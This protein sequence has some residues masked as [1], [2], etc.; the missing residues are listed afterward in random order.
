MAA[1]PIRRAKARSPGRDWRRWAR[2]RFFGH[3]VNGEP[4][5]DFGRG[6]LLGGQQRPLT[7]LGFIPLMIGAGY[8]DPVPALPP[9]GGGRCRRGF[10]ACSLAIPLSNDGRHTI[11][12]APFHWPPG[13]LT[14]TFT[15]QVTRS[16]RPYNRTSRQRLTFS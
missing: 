16:G 3:P 13:F 8:I 1:A 5:A 15:P 2:S 14:L 9:S 7:V 11:C 10:F 4:V 6:D 12:S